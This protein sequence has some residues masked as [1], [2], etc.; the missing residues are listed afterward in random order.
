MHVNQLCDDIEY[1][2]KINLLDGYNENTETDEIVLDLDCS[3]TSNEDGAIVHIYICNQFGLV[4]I[5]I[6]VWD[7]SSRDKFIQRIKNRL[8]ALPIKRTSTEREKRNMNNFLDAQF[9]KIKTLKKIGLDNS[10]IKT[11]KEMAE[12]CVESDDIEDRTNYAT[13]ICEIFAP[14][15]GR[16]CDDEW[17]DAG[18]TNARILLDKNEGT[19][20][21]ALF[22]MGTAYLMC[23]RIEKAFDCFNLL[24]EDKDCDPT[25][26]EVIGEEYSVLVRPD[27]AI[28]INYKDKFEN[29]TRTLSEEE[30]VQFVA[31]LIARLESIP[32]PINSWD[33]T[34]IDFDYNRT[35]LTA[36]LY[37]IIG[38]EQKAHDLC[39]KI[40]DNADSV[41]DFDRLIA[42]VILNS[43]A[44]ELSNKIYNYALKFVKNNEKDFGGFSTEVYKDGNYLTIEDYLNDPEIF[45]QLAVS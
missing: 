22:K 6:D 41:Y 34:D 4:A 19:N 11:M 27:I 26:L 25:F 40:I 14:Y 31:K 1:V 12:R 33:R 32:Y 29:L 44:T 16:E 42:P 2:E 8:K 20:A 23:N 36:N 15:T 43:G 45:F 38:A 7:E 37:S 10:E 3:I 30:R 21:R 24:L 35:V 17:V 39:V 13:S 18:L 28:S 5:I 9:K